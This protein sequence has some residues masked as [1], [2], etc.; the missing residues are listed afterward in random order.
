MTA[1]DAYLTCPVCD[2]VPGERCYTLRAV[3]GPAVGRTAQP[4]P[5]EVPHSARKVSKRA[6]TAVTR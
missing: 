3:Y 2:A 6:S 5:A 4:I 1:W